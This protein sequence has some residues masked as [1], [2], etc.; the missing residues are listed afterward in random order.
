MC[1]YKVCLQLLCVD[2][3]YENTLIRGG[4]MC[5]YKVCLQLL[6]VDLKFV[7]YSF[8]L[9]VFIYFSRNPFFI[10]LFNL[11]EIDANRPT[12]AVPNPVLRI[13]LRPQGRRVRKILFRDSG[14][15]INVT[16]PRTLGFCRILLDAAPAPRNTLGTHWEQ[17]RNTLGTHVNGV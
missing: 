5:S 8:T 4:V 1:S 12:A 6:C 11:P 15:I 2:L 9:A 13:I 7:S 10:Y 3:M 14:T 16:Q 17:I